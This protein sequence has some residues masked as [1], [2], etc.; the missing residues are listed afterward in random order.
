MHHAGLDDNWQLEVLLEPVISQSLP[1]DLVLA[2]E[3]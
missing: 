3:L 1:W 2:S